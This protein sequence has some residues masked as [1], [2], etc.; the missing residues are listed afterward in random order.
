MD[1]DQASRY[2]YRFHDT[3][4]RG[5][6]GL[7]RSVIVIGQHVIRDVPG[8]YRDN[9]QGVICLIFLNLGFLVLEG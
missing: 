1:I 3:K 9:D 4:L 8:Y 5:V 6:E 7:E 2:F